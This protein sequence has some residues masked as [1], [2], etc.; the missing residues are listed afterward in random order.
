M[1]KELPQFILN[2]SYHLRT[3]LTHPDSG[4]SVYFIYKVIGT[5]AMVYDTSVT[6]RPLHEHHL[7]YPQG[8]SSHTRVPMRRHW[9][10]EHTC[11]ASSRPAGTQV[12]VWMRGVPTRA[13]QGLRRASPPSSFAPPTPLSCSARTAPCCPPQDP[14]VAEKSSHGNEINHHKA[15]LNCNVRGP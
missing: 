2:P 11:A 9:L 13:T 8:R 4:L 6:S 12:W 14:P 15:Q 7:V 5:K 1:S 10:R 3:P